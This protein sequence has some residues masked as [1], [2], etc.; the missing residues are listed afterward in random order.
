MTYPSSERARPFLDEVREGARKSGLPLHIISRRRHWQRNH[1][2][3]PRL[4]RDPHRLVCLRGHDPRGAK[5][6][7]LDPTRCPLRLVVTVVSTSRPGQAIVDAGQKAFTSYPA[8]PLWLLRR[9]A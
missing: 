4:H 8:D 3:I 7:D 9:A 1:L 6:D 2:Q 5:R